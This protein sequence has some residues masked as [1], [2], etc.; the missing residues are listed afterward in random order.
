MEE[1]PSLPRASLALGTGTRL[2][3]LPLSSGTCKITARAPKAGPL[4][5]AAGARWGMPWGSRHMEEHAVPGR[6]GRAARCGLPAL[7]VKY[8]FLRLDVVYV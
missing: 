2:L 1:L 3:A 6:R 4:I 8:S 5:S 7:N